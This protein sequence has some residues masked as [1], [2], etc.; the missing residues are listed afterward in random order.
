[1]NDNINEVKQNEE[2]LLPMSESESLK[3]KKF[4]MI[5]RKINL[6]TAIIIAVVIVVGVLAY[7]YKGSFIAVTVN[8][9]PISRF[10][11][12]GKL[13]K[14]SGKQT[15]DSLITQKLIIGELDKE[16]ITVT[17]DEINA[18]IKK[19]EDQI[20]AQ[21]NTLAQ[22]LTAQG[23]TAADLRDQVSINLRIEKLLTDKIQVSNDEISQYI[24]DNKLTV[25]KGQEAQYNDQIRS[26]LK[27]DKLSQAAQDWVNSIRSQASIHYFVNY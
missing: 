20:T 23:M 25:P 1:M 18:D 15:L 11:V 21:G 9:S 27:S 19:I 16:K 17:D 13:E 14:T 3:I 24:K 26:Q 12:I 7:I 5:I 8:G 4:R 22:A 6:K 2:E 10:A